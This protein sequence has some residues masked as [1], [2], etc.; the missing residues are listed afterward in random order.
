MLN[1][2]AALMH[3]EKMLP[4]DS[5]VLCALSG[6]A[7]SV[8]LLHALCCLQQRLGFTLCAAHYNHQLRGG[9]SDRDE[10][11]VREL[12][13]THFPGIELVIGRGDVAGEARR[14]GMG[15]EETAREMRYAFLRQAA[16]ELGCGRIAV[17]HTADDNAETILLHLGRG[18][19][20]QGLTG[21]SPVRGEIIRPL[22][23]STRADVE[24]YLK[25]NS[26]P[27]V[28]D[29]SNSDQYYARNRVRAQVVPVLEGLYPGF[30]RRLAENSAR[31]REDEAYLSAQAEELARQG[32]VT[33]DGV[34]ISAQLLARFPA[35]IALRAVRILL[36][37]LRE[38][39][40]TCAASHLEAVLGLCRGDAPSGEVHLPGELLAVREYDR[41]RLCF[42][43]REDAPSPA[44]LALPGETDF[45]LWRIAAEP[46]VYAGQAHTGSELWLRRTGLPPL[47][48]RRRREGDRLKLPN[49][50]TKSVK[51]WLIDLKIPRL[52]RDRLPVLGTQDAAAAVALVGP[53]TQFTPGPDEAAWH[54]VFTRPENTQGGKSGKKDL[55]PCKKM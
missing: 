48:V 33:P 19:G 37:D 38:G 50:P 22:L 32:A 40:D 3:T 26:L 13:R 46:C 7:D 14:R 24:G 42:R 54:I 28:E 49:R 10:N 25:E 20:L 52:D 6:G 30:A 2:I 5:R 9:E 51:K 11:F 34:T 16:R 35:P 27:H 45:G 44:P 4:P 55:D 53:D 17:A 21:I 47:T 43:P 36:K 23:T 8:C 18:T 31:L 29:S 12:L 39:D 41:L 1:T 15:L